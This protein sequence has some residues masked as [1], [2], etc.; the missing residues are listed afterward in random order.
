MRLIVTLAFCFGLL[1]SQ[2][3]AAC[4]ANTPC[5]AGTGCCSQWGNCGWGDDFCGK[6]CLNNC[7]AV[8]AETECSASKPCATGCC[9]Q[10]GNCGWG[11]D[12]CGKGCLSSCDAVSECDANR[13]C[14]TGCC[15]TNGVCGT[16]PDYCSPE[17]C[18]NS[19]EF[20][21]E[22]DPG[23]WGLDYVKSS[24]CPLN[25][26]CSDFGFCGTTEGFCGDKQPERPSCSV[27]SHKIDR[28]V[29]YY[30]SWSTAR[31]CFGMS[32]LMIPQGVYTHINFAFVSI[33]PKTF[34]VVPTSSSDYNLYSD[35]K[36]LKT[37]DAG[38]QLWLAIGGWTFNDDTSPTVTTFSDLARA[39]I[40]YQNVFFSSLTLFMMTFGF[41]GIDI[42]WEYPGA[43][44][45]NGRS[46]DYENFPKFLKNLKT[47]LNAYGYGLSITIPTSY[48]YLQH[49]DIAA[50]EPYID[51]FNVMSYDLHGTWDI[52][53][54]E[55]AGAVLNAHTNLTEIEKALD[56][57]WRNDISPSKITLGMAFYGRT[58]TLIG[59]C[60]TP[61]C[62]YASA[63]DKGPCSKET[64]ILLN[65]EIASIIKR[66]NLTP[67]LDKDAAVKTMT[68][69]QNQ[70]VS[71][72]DK[73]TF[74]L[75]GDF[76][77]SQC[78][79]GVMVWAISHDD[80][81]GT[82]AYGLAEALGNE[83]KVD[84]NTGIS[85]A[86]TGITSR[87]AGGGGNPEDAFCRWSNCGELC[88]DGFS[89]IIRDDKKSEIMMDASYCA[90]SDSLLHQHG[91]NG[92]VGEC[93]WT[94][95]TGDA[96]KC[97]SDFPN[98]VVSAPS[99]SGGLAA[100]YAT[101]N[102]CCKGSSVPTAFANCGW[103]AQPAQSSDGKSGYCMDSCPAGQVQIASDTIS[104]LAAAHWGH[105]TN[106][107]HC[108]TGYKAF[109]CA[110]PKDKG[111]K[112]DPR[113]EPILYQDQ[114]AS[115]FDAYLQHYLTAPICPGTWLAE[116]EAVTPNHVEG[117][118]NL[119]S[120]ATDMT[121]TLNFLTP[122]LYVLFA[123]QY[124]RQDLAEIFD[125][126]M[127]EFGMFG[128]DAPAANF[129]EVYNTLWPNGYNGEA[130]WEPHS[131]LADFLCN[132]QDS[133][134]AMNNLAG[135]N[136]VFCEYAP[137]SRGV[138]GKRAP[139]NDFVLDQSSHRLAHR[140][141]AL[142]P[143]PME[144]DSGRGRN[145]NQPTIARALEGVLSGN[146]SFHYA[147]WIPPS[148]RRSDVILE[149]AFWI[150]PQVGVDPGQEFR[151]R[152]R[153]VYIKHITQHGANNE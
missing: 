25:V 92:A 21:A 134:F 26:C 44:D 115:L 36:A 1:A 30:E 104:G 74:K 16:G 13:P 83:L 64:G 152:Y 149:L 101:R 88:S 102:Y 121:S 27:D 6:G 147:R 33:D 105:G 20:K 32:P 11:A 90:K 98:F 136:E 117:A 8:P 41:T 107:P 114:D 55:W 38:L 62:T 128:G 68:W 138:I 66:E 91:I 76:A 18:I 137:D 72:D 28:V 37:R 145:P 50:I 47:A 129:T 4:G 99:G 144:P 93:L 86:G 73:D 85:W 17:K 89:E 108:S 97:P 141:F 40:T 34:E 29:G 65:S 139:D 53:G 54:G 39:D 123:S 69:G 113:S 10:F 120:R 3:L 77:K 22:C 84:K 87:A 59:S 35:L 60:N 57:V 142:L 150:G 56:L 103:S 46:E 135:A 118:R 110:A 67:A 78:L 127:G 12:F 71:F 7:D 116:H 94:G 82:S 109:C 31:S 126:R 124:A 96:G 70:W 133:R 119:L 146:L 106:M 9:S 131:F 52:D 100:C 61:G 132:L 130:S 51:W 49:F 79:G 140:H 153:Y 58:T 111:S 24:K 42:D 125:L 112:P 143:P 95:C 81:M 2:A 48:W 151:N 23:G 14:K 43:D 19:C 63:G 75:K 15:G 80:G 122:L 45:R 5:P 148:A